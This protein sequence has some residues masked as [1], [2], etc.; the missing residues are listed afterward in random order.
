VKN[1][2]NKEEVPPLPPFLPEDGST[3]GFRNVVFKEKHWTM[4]KVIKQDSSKM[5]HTIVRT[6]Q[7]RIKIPVHI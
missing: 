7:N 5:H 4:D 6:L 1:L 3:A 2:Q